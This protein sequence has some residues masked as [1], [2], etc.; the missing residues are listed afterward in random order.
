M[1]VT[2]RPSKRGWVKPKKGAE[3]AAVSLKVFY[4]W[5]RDGLRHVRLANNRI[6]TQ[7][8]WIDSY[9]QGFE[10]TNSD[11]HRDEKVDQNIG[12]LKTKMGAHK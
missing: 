5:L 3:Y 8:D 10:V 1:E 9:L 6:L 12:K 7:Y 4:R 2:Y 11:L